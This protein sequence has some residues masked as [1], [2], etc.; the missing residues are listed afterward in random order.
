MQRQ[1]PVRAI[2]SKRSK[3]RGR[4]ITLE[5]LIQTVAVAEH[6]SFLHAA[7]TLGVGQS[8]L[9][10]RIKRLEGELGVKLFDRSTRGVRVTQAGEPFIERIADAVARIEMAVDEA[11]R[12][13]A[14]E[15]GSL[16]IGLHHLTPDSFLDDLLIRYRADHPGIAVELGEGSGSETIARL[17]AGR[18]DVAF[19]ANMPDLP[20]CHARPIW[21]ET[22]W[23]ALPADH[24]LAGN[25]GVTWAELA[26]ETFL[27]RNGGTGPQVHDYLVQ[28]LGRN[29]GPGPSAP[30]VQWLNVER[31]TLLSMVARSF[32]V[33]IVGASTAPPPVE[34]VAFLPLTDEAE[35]AIFSAIW[36][37]H[38][39]TAPLRNLFAL[40]DAMN[41]AT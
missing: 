22:L 21:T 32:G 27:V 39:R 2:S 5:C 29:L 40:A 7:G 34:G 9:S 37:P 18:I 6:L 12:E 35:P 24:P 15:H 1:T 20:D 13:A 25:P 17:R 23:A 3:L 11:G 14:G 38:N 10:A 33:T 31:A 26:D 41:A 36:S 16:R 4:R 28:R 30:R 19:I 8:S